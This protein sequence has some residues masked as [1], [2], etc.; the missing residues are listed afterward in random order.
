MGSQLS[1]A[2][3]DPFGGEDGD[4]DGRGARLYLAVCCA[5]A[6]ASNGP[7]HSSAQSG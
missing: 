7:Q 4:G 6:G 2:R 1:S 3:V 5:T